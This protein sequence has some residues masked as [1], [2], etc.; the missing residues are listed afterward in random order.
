MSTT[1]FKK[2]IDELRAKLNELEERVDAGMIEDDLG[3]E[4][5]EADL[6]AWLARNFAALEKTS[7]D[8]YEALARG[9]A[10]TGT[11]AEHRA[12]F[13]EKSRRRAINP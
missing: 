9:E 11:V 2:E 6:D 12:R 3:P 10:F 7:L 13:F 4:A 5:N 8:G 1:I